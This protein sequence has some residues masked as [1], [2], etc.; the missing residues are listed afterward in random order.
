MIKV[1]DRLP[2]PGTQVIVFNGSFGVAWYK[3]QFGTTDW[4]DSDGDWRGVT[5]WESLPERPV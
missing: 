2:E 1:K 3:A 4:S 5:H